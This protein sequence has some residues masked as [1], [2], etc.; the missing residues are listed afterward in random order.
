[1]K[2]IWR[3]LSLILALII[4]L[5]RWIVSQL[6]RFVVYNR[7]TR[8][9]HI[10]A[11]RTR[12]EKNKSTVLVVI[13]HIASSDEIRSAKKGSD[14]VEKLNKT[15]EGV[16]SSLAHCEW[17]IIINTMR[18]RHITA[19][20]PEYQHSLI[21]VQEQEECDP[22]FVGFKAQDELIERID[23]FDWFLFIEDDIVIHDSCL[24]DKLECFNKHSSD[25]RAV[26][27][28]NRY[29]IWQGMKTYIDYSYS[30]KEQSVYLQCNGL[31]KIEI[32]DVKFGEFHNP[33]S[34]FYCL[35]RKQLQIWRDS[36]RFWQNQVVLAGPLE[37]AATGCL[38]ECF[39]L[40]KPAT[41]N[42]HFL[43]VQHWDTKY[44]QH[45]SSKEYKVLYQ[46]T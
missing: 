3:F 5:Y 42:L 14:K 39:S 40:Y 20:L 28:P 7:R 41:E 13:T 18:G 15:I 36:G 22:M 24:L 10:L 12:I 34:G 11:D 21:K 17:E 32:G 46:P 38:F 4:E 23:K 31:S 44:S 25:D 1:M 45:I 43:E 19:Y 27:L 29:E 37:S 9:I 35:S 16:V 6:R 26:L 33:H 30:E 8:V 2:S